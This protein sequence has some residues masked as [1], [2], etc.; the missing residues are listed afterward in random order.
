MRPGPLESQLTPPTA[1]AGMITNV[2]RIDAIVSKR[3]TL[4]ADEGMSSSLPR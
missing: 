2:A 1:I 3:A 4:C